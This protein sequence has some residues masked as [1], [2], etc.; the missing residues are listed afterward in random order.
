MRPTTGL[1]YFPLKRISWSTP[2]ARR[3]AVATELACA[4]LPAGSVIGQI[5]SWVAHRD[6]VPVLV[7]EEYWTCKP[8]IPGWDLALDGHT[9]RVRAEGVPNI[10]VELCVDTDPVAE[11]G[12]VSGGYVAVGISAIRA[13]L[14]VLSAEPGVVI[15]EIFGAYRWPASGSEKDV[16]R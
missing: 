2:P 15:P 5:L 3:T 7:A 10:S 8:D 4:T 16:P 13:I 14:Y 6:G 9:V 11:F 12:G 1:K